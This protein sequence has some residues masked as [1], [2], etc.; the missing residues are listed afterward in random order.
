MLIFLTPMFLFGQQVSGTVTSETGE[1]LVGANVVVDG[2]VPLT[3][4]PKRNIGVRKINIIE[5]RLRYIFIFVLL[6]VY[7]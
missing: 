3:C 4:C 2:T 5:I 1:P 6:V 7:C